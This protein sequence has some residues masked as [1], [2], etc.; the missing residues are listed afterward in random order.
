[1]AAGD[2]RHDGAFCAI[3]AVLSWD[4]LNR[5]V[6]LFSFLALA[7]CGCSTT[8]YRNTSYYR[9]TLE[10][11]EAAGKNGAPGN[12]PSTLRAGTAKVE[13]TPPIGMP[14]Q[15]FGSRRGEPS[16]G[17]HDPL[18]A[19][20]LVLKND[21]AQLVLV[22]C[23]L[24]GVT[25][26][27]T[28]AVFEKAG[29]KVPLARSEFVMLA[30]HTH[31]GAGGLSDRFAMQF[32]GGRFRP[33]LFAETTDRIAE[34]VVRASRDTQPAQI[35][36]GSGETTDLNKN[37]SRCG[38]PVDREVKVLRV[39]NGDGR[40]IA[41]L[42]NF[43]AHPTIFGANWEFTADFPG[44]L[45]RELEQDGAVA[46]FANGAAGDLNIQGRNDPS[47][48][49]KA[50]RAGST[51]AQR[52]AEIASK[53]LRK[54]VVEMET[55]YVE[56]LLPPVRIRL[57]GAAIPVWLGNCLFPR[58]LPVHLARIDHTLF[59][60]VPF[61]LNA[62][63]GL[64]WKQEAA[65]RGHDLFVLGYANDYAGYVVP[66]RNYATTCYEARTS[67][68]GPQLD[69]YLTEVFVKMMEGTAK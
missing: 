28:D 55:R 20:V 59:V 54:D 6:L 7:L 27:L 25:R 2:A 41:W 68:Y 12:A 37:R 4:V 3:D 61:E 34:A 39:T 40:P 14:L 67:F 60:T 22:S 17:V 23:D 43:A 57:D 1:M 13:I 50:E 26:N 46:L 69:G 19:R 48:E 66:E 52:G 15:G 9:V 44:Y 29:R 32:V 45:C 5:R 56:A 49:A 8:D 36:F 62:E 51:L 16:R 31:S 63:I 65:K 11:I 42:V 58:T 30:T 64:A 47:K 38:G 24:M 35:S 33:S 18:F 21:H 10:R 53:L